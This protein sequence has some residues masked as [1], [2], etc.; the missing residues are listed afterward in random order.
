MSISI[1]ITLTYILMFQL[2]RPNDLINIKILGIVLGIGEIISGGGKGFEQS[3][4][5][6][7]PN[8]NGQHRP[9]CLLLSIGAS[10]IAS[11]R[12]CHFDLISLDILF[13][14][15]L[16]FL[17]FEHEALLLFAFLINSGCPS[18]ALAVL[19]D[20]VYVDG[21]RLLVGR[22]VLA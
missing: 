5:S 15:I 16:R 2:K 18:I 14:F 19:V 9:L 17:D 6:L 11:L 1:I 12:L 8:S 13:A 22:F 4:W 7:F 20:L 3:T 10:F 21:I